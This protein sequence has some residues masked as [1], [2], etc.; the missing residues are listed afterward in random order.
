MAMGSAADFFGGYDH[1]AEAGFVHVADH[2]IAPGKKQW[3]WGNAAFGQ[4]VGP[5]T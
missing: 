4:R 2:R 3:T 5:R 1:A